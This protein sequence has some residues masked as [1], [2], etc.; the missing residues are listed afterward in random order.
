MTGWSKHSGV[1]VHLPRDNIDTDQLIPAR[2]MSQPRADGYQDFLLY[3]IR[4]YGHGELKPDFVLNQVTD[5][6]VLLAGDNFGSGSSREAAAYALCDTGF[7]AVLA[8]SFGD[9]F[10]AN[11]INNGLLPAIIT[12]QSKEHM[13]SILSSGPEHCEI[14]LHSKTICIGEYKTE[15][16]IDDAQRIKLINGWN[17]IDLTQQYND[18]ISSFTNSRKQQCSW[19]W[20]ETQRNSI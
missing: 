8:T 2:F 19:V 15:F 7:R 9:I 14:D 6:S 20:P 10:A 11:A 17:D 18:Q 5:A 12:K 1:I 16:S 3:D 13:A 4:R